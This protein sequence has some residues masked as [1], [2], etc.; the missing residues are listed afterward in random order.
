M[1]FKMFM[2]CFLL[3]QIRKIRKVKAINQGAKVVNLRR[4]P[5]NQRWFWDSVRASSLH[6]LIYTCYVNV[7]HALLMALCE[8]WHSETSS[9]HFPIG[10]TSIT[11][12]DIACLLHIPI[13]WRM[14]NH[15][16]NVSQVT[17]VELLVAYLGVP[18][19]EAVKNCKDE[20]GAYISYKVLKKLY[21]DHLSIATRLIDAQTVE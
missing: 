1:V 18:Q 13:E 15:P 12:D 21:E 16:K 9:F 19:N 7:P 6:D 2:L 4:P 20:Y 3:F 11:L 14:L 17:G 5:N 8:R 10:E